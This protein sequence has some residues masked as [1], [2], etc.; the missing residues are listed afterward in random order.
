MLGGNLSFQFTSFVF[1]ALLLLV[2]RGSGPLSLDHLLRID[3]EKEPDLF[4]EA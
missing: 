3:E 4:H 1:F 2:W